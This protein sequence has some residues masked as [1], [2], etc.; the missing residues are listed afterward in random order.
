M[1][2]PSNSSF[3]LCN[4]G[5]QHNFTCEVTGN[6]LVWVFG[7][8]DAV[9]GSLFTDSEQLGSHIN[10]HFVSAG[11][12]TVVANA[13]VTASL[14]LNGT[15]LECRNTSGL[16]DTTAR[17]FVNFNVKGKYYKVR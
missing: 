17:A 3:S 10:T 16:S 7:N 1:I 5:V 2:S 12:G 15:T 4:D 11:G 6:T 9:F 14:E 8:E 13:T